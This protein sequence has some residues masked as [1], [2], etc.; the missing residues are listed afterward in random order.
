MKI[1]VY[2]NSMAP[3]GGIERVISRHIEFLIDQHEITLFTKDD[4]TSFYA[5]PNSVKR[6]SLEIDMTL[7]MNS[8]LKRIFTIAT[9]FFKTVLR[10]RTLFKNYQPDIIYLASPLN[11]F[12]VFISQLSCRKI[13]VTE[14]S[15]FSA[16]NS[17]YKLIARILY[18][19]ITLLTVPTQDDSIYYSSQG[20]KNSYLPNPL[21]FFPQNPSNLQNKVVLNVGRL[22]DDKRHE[23][24]INLW[25]MTKGKDKNWKL[26]IIGKGENAEKL[27]KLILTLKLEK[28]VFLLPTTKEIESEFTSA[29]IFALTSKNEG[30]G[31]V[32]A[33]A[34]ASGVPCISFNCPSG[35]KDI[36][37][38]G[39]TGYLIDEGDERSF[40]NHLDE[41]MENENL[42]RTLGT[43]A[44]IDIKRFDERTVSEKLNSL[45]K[46]HF[47]V[48][49][50]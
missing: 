34:M 26:N 29:S 30:F 12:E 3:A 48:I 40:V 38:D 2:F 10:L 41:L 7:D 28:C 49:N 50:C 37:A 22:T 45:I 31:L 6:K 27:K 19:K 39:I 36:I 1:A 20:I 43:K 25:S 42:R 11:L 23:L 47:A 4:G 21:S 5:L 24:L 8:Q 46:T 32:L 13:L 44:R 33:E 16:Y 14:H 9:T 18:K 15:S 17:V 35:P